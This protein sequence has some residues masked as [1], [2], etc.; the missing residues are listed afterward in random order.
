[1]WSIAVVAAAGGAEAGSGGGIAERLLSPDTGLLFWTPAIF[2]ALL[3]ILWRFG[4]G[5]MIDKLDERDRAIRGAVEEAGRERSE[6]QKLLAEN[7]RLLEETRRKTSEMLGEAESAAKVERQRILDEARDE[8]TR[9][10]ERGR[11]QIEQETNNALAQ[12]RG[13]VVDLAIETTRKLIPRV[14]D[15]SSHR[16]LAE[17]FVRELESEKDDGAPRA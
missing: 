14:V 2:I 8:S 1:M 17:Q 12:I 9:I 10:V 3:I 11:K 13:S 6:A 15:E 5:T 4:W 7:K 16:D